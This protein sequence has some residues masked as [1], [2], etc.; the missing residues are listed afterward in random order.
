MDAFLVK[1]F[2]EGLSVFLGAIVGVVD[3]DLTAGLEK[4]PDE[5]LTVFRDSL[6]EIQGLGG[7]LS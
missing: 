3:D 1:L 7:F 6:A 5:F 4:A 2:R